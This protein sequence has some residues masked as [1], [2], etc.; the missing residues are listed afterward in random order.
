MSVAFDAKYDR[1]R[2]DPARGQVSYLHLRDLSAALRP[3]LAHVTGVW[4]DF[5]SGTSPYRRHMNGA[6]LLS[7]DMAADGT[8]QPDFL[9]EP[10]QPCGAPDGSFDGI[11]ST[12]VLEHVEDP[13]FYLGDAFRMLRPG[14]E[15]LLT[16]HGIWEDHPCPL[17]QRR[18]TAQGLRYEVV[19]AGF[20]VRECVPLTCGF[21]AVVQ[22]MGQEAHRSSWDW[23]GY[24]SPAGA[25]LGALRVVARR[26]PR[27]LN[28]AADRLLASDAAGREGDAKLYLALLIAARKPA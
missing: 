5:G 16:T 13:A 11:L 1:V 9:I 7:A 2:Q 22:L 12:Q 10:G 8:A 17:D 20:E 18:W 24:L 3:R 4:L 6:R 25:L 23:R 19:H 21:R 26:S 15:L 27:A 28:L 14:G